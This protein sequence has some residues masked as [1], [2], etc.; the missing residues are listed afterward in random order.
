MMSEDQINRWQLINQDALEFILILKEKDVHFDLIYVD[1][2]FADNFYTKILTLLPD[3]LKREGSVIVEHFHKTKLKESYGR[4][5]S[6]KDRR[7]GDTCLSFFEL[8][9]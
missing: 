2:P 3:I 6:F 7:L 1:P 5:K 4:L 8:E 9:L